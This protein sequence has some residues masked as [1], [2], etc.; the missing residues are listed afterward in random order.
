MRDLVFGPSLE[1]AYSS[2]HIPLV[3]RTGP[4]APSRCQGTGKHNL[5]GIPGG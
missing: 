1:V 3:F 5:P 2:A 4:L